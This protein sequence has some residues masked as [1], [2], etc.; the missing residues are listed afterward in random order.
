MSLY[1][2][3]G[4]RCPCKEARG[5]LLAPAPEPGSRLLTR[6]GEAEDDS[7]SSISDSH[8]GLVW[9]ACVAAQRSEPGAGSRSRTGC[10]QQVELHIWVEPR[11]QP[12]SGTATNR[13]GGCCEMASKR[14]GAKPCCGLRNEGER[15]DKCRGLWRDSWG[16]SELRKS[17]KRIIEL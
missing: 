16:T 12:G 1:L 13:R 9:H 17:Q 2:T 3:D 4:S 14:C 8:L 11:R 5:A 7:L 6:S 15:S 10:H